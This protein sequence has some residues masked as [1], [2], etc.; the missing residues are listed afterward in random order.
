[1]RSSW[2]TAGA[3]AMVLVTPTTLGAVSR[4]PAAPAAKPAAAAPAAAPAA[5]S[6]RSRAA[7]SWDRSS[8]PATQPARDS[9]TFVVGN[10]M[11]APR[12][13]RGADRHRH[14]PY[15]LR[16]LNTG[17]FPVALRR[18]DTL[19]ARTGAVLATRQGAAL[20]ALVKRPEGGDFTGEI[21]AGLTAIAILDVALPPRGRLPRTLVHR[22]S[23]SYEES[24]VPPG[25]VA[26]TTYLTGPTRVARRHAPVIGAPLRGSG[27]VA[28]N[29]C[30]ATR[31]DH[32]GG[33]VPVNGRLQLPE[34]FA[35]DFVRIDRNRRLFSGPV[36]ALSSYAYYGADVLSVADG[37]V[38]RAH[39]GE[40]EQT[41][42]NA[43]PPFD[44]ETAPGNSVVT[45]IGHGRFAVYAHLQG[46]LKVKVGDRVR[47]GQVLGLLGNTG[48][49][50]HP[51][52]HFQVMDSPSYADSD[53]RPYQFTR[54]T[55]VGTVT[56]EQRLF[57]G[58]PAPI[59]PQ[60]SGRHHRKLPLNLQ[61]VDFG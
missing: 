37:T 5:P 46:G 44:L 52:L 60:L 10:V 16:L 49:S 50:T 12:V 43:P 9:F 41:P 28:V 45:D 14:L 32:R 55:S 54:F 31:T 4:H 20:T 13:V 25:I 57:T 34:R 48:S 53:G 2:L 1:M 3:L 23:I 15:E 38:V 61:V 22:L 8:K 24:Q 29:G 40:P 42:P 17:F 47:R 35:I 19:D 33:A 39:D 36:E 58:E 59:G 18:V 6:T 51:H 26:A 21:G 30:C 11:S 27:W 56:D 7:A